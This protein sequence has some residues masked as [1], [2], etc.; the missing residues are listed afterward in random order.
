MYDLHCH[1]LPGIDDGAR[2]MAESLVLAEMAQADGVQGLVVTP[3]LHPGRWENTRAV[4]EASVGELQT[5]LVQA[6]LSVKVSWSAEV[7]LSDDILGLVGEG[8]IPFYGEIDGHQLML[9]EFPHGHIVPGS[10]KLVDWL[11]SRGI[12]PMIAHPERNKAVMRDPDLIL[13]F[14]EKG[15]WLQVTANSITGDFGAK[16]HETAAWLL[17]RDL[18]TLVASDAHNARYRTPRLSAAYDRVAQT[19]GALRAQTLFVTRPGEVFS[20]A[21]TRD[22]F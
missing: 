20:A 13:P 21:L 8:Q 1:L 7:R 9:L 2:D 14:V 15:C 5:A 19:Y 6:G 22:G 11:L 4:V 10:D 3:H 12:R 17:Q 16:A 18:V